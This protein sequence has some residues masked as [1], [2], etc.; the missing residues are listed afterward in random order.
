[1]DANIYVVVD[2]RATGER[3]IVYSGREPSEALRVRDMLIGAGDHAA[4]VE[5]VH[6]G[7]D[8]ADQGNQ[9]IGVT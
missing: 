8:D 6:A 5:I 2:Q 7:E 1:V 4:A 3:R 9:R